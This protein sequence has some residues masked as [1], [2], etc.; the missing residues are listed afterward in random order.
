MLLSSSNLHV[1]L[2]NHEESAASSAADPSSASV[3]GA[4]E[5]VDGV[6][7]TDEDSASAPSECLAPTG[8]RGG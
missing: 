8:D 3:D 2:S 7:K 4:V 1:A 5:I 6:P